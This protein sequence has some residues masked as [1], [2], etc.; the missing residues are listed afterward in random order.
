MI[1][2]L[3]LVSSKNVLMV[4][5]VM[6]FLASVSCGSEVKEKKKGPALNEDNFSSKKKGGVFFGMLPCSDCPRIIYSIQLNLDYTYRAEILYQGKQN[7]IVDKGNYKITAKDIIVLN[8]DDSTLRY[9]FIHPDKLELLDQNGKHYPEQIASSYFLNDMKDITSDRLEEDKKN[10]QKMKA[11]LGYDFYAMGDN[12]SWNLDLDF[13]KQFR[14]ITITG[15]KFYAPPVEGEISGDSLVTTYRS[16]SESGNIIII[17][18]KQNC[19]RITREIYDYRV[20]VIIKNPD[21]TDPLYFDGCGN[22]I[23]PEFK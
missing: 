18:S 22:F 6:G 12:P 5:L 21:G 10:T 8:N 7:K 4:I 13:D 20:E 19:T 16:E 23:D 17:V 3:V 11:D 1:Q 9:F 14:L 15:I 2:K